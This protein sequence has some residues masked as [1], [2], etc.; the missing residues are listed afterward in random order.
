MIK[1]SIE[2]E[3]R[4]VEMFVEETNSCE[5][6]DDMFRLM[7]AWGYHPQSIARSMQATGEEWLDED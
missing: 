4:S 5:L 2:K 7:V 3:D 6:V 1:I